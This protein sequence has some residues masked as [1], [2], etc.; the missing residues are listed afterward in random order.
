MFLASDLVALMV[1]TSILEDMDIYFTMLIFT[2]YIL[3]RPYRSTTNFNN[4]LAV[5]IM[6]P[7]LPLMVHSWW[8]HV[9]NS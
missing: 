9:I 5:Y 1:P 3:L 4:H 7:S 6:T 8:T 2:V